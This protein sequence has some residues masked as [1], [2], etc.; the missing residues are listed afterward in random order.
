MLL[1]V[2]FQVGAIWGDEYAPRLGSFALSRGDLAFRLSQLLYILPASVLVAWAIGSLFADHILERFERLLEGG[3]AGALVLAAI[4]VAGAAAF[5]FL[6]LEGT[7][8]TDDENVY[9][10]QAW[11]V[12]HGALYAPSLPPP[13]RAFFDNQ[14]VVNDGRWYGLYFVGHPA[15]LALADLLQVGALLGPASAGAVV[16]LTWAIGARVFDR[17]VAVAACTL[18]A[19]SPFLAALFATRLSQPTDAL[20]LL[21]ATWAVLRIEADPGKARWW[22]LAAAAASLALVTRPQAAVPFL[23]P[24]LVPVAWN[25]ARGR[26]RPGAAPPLTGLLVAAMGFAVF[27]MVNAI[28]NG[29]PLRTGYH[30]YT[31]QGH[32]WLTPVGFRY[33]VRQAAE[34]LGHLSFWL[35]GWPLSLMFLPFFERRPFALRLAASAVLVF[36]SF[37]AS[38]VPTVA[39]VG[40]VY[41]GE[42]IPVLAL[43]SA[44]GWAVVTSW[45]SLGNWRRLAGSTAVYP[46]AAILFALLTFVPT[47]AWWLWRSSRVVSVPYRVAES[48]HLSNA[49]VFVDKMPSR[50]LPPHSWAYFH[51]N[52]APDLTDPVIWVKDLGDER[53]RELMRFLGRKGYRLI[54]PGDTVRLEPIAP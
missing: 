51:R 45:V 47:Q 26:L 44:S 13:F 49:L 46:V 10:F 21:V 33:S 31:A 18:L 27:L 11:L 1:V 8:V 12:R 25:L 9:A 34:G 15:V 28:Q 40:P 2:A 24:L 3:R 52:P 16:L 39:P 29:S 6:I 48:Q 50:V 54:P 43:L 5:R 37:A 41:Y 23:L 53:N 42:L 14:F 36:V 30:A 19:F 22:V 20:A 17:R 38:A 32:P 7:E 4:A 35:F